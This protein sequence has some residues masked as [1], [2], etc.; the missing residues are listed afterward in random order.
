PDGVK[1]GMLR[2]VEQV[3]VVEHVILEY[4]PRYVVLDAVVISSKGNILMPQEVFDAMERILFPLA[5]IEV[6]KK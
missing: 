5:T 1:L 2:T 3:Q 4:H 6:I